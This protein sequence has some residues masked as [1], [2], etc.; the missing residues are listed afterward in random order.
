V[1][2]VVKWNY[3]AY[4]VG[5]PE[6][7]KT[8]IAAMIARRHLATMPTG[9]LFVHDPVAQ[10]AKHGCLYFDTAIAW[11]AAARDAATKQTVMPRG[12]SL[13]GSASEV[14]AL[15]LELGE[16]M[17]R[18]DSVRVPILLVYDEASLMDAS[19]GTYMGALDNTLLATRRHRGVGLVFNLQDPGQLTSR[20]FRMGTDFYLMAQTSRGAAKLDELLYLEKGTLAAAGVTQL[21][22]HRYLHVRQ[23]E[24]VVG[25]AL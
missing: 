5:P 3:C 25:D 18:A 1:G 12:A 21:E 11:R 16:K 13:G 2:I 20:F 10:F 19:G 24:G 14:T 6:Y 9:I 7:G 17:N 23:R 22:K 15:A 4:V 8:T